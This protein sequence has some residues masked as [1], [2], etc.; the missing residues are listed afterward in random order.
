VKLL[1]SQK[2]SRAA[3]TDFFSPPERKASQAERIRHFIQ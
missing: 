1:W 3:R 2:P